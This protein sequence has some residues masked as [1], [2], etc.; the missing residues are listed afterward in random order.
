VL[1]PDAAQKYGIVN[2]IEVDS[3]GMVH[4]PNNP[5]LGMQIDFDLINKNKVFEL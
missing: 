4:A 3:N 1:L 2:D 5:G